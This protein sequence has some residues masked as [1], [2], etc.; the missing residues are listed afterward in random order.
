MVR[1]RLSPIGLFDRVAAICVLVAV[2]FV[3]SVSFGHEGHDHDDGARAALI[4]S[5]FPR[6]TAKSELYEIVGILKDGRLSIYLDRLATNEAVGDAQVKVT[7]G[8]REPVDAEPA[9]NATYSVPFSSN[10]APESFEVVFTVNAQDG[11]DL[12]VGRHEAAASC[13]V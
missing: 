12:L 8:D 6:V 5:A 10:A 2:L 4:A 13:V 9:A 11:D 1:Y 3:G 7:I